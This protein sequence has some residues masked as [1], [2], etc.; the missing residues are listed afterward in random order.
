MIECLRSLSKM[1]I[2]YCIS[3]LC[4]W[5]GAFGDYRRLRNRE[6]ARRVRAR[7]LA[8]VSKMG[9]TLQS[10]QDENAALKAH[11]NKLQS[12][13]QSMTLKVYEVT[14]KYESAVADNAR[15]RTELFRFRRVSVFVALV[16]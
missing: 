6:S 7:R 4:V 2:T 15:L 1:V 3:S 11:V 12:H 16:A 8:E 14:A 9:T 10:I 13:I 5:G